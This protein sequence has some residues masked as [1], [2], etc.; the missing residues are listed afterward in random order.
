MFRADV[1]AIAARFGIDA[2]RLAA[3][4]R[5]ADTLVSLRDATTSQAGGL[6][7]AARDRDDGLPRQAAEDERDPDGSPQ[8]GAVSDEDAP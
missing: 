6:L 4:I 8:P 3:L 5:A 1:E 2:A 7:A